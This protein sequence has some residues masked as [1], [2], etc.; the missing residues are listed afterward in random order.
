MAILLI[1]AADLEVL[2]MITVSICEDEAYFMSELNKLMDEYCDSRKIHASIVTFSDGEK[3]LA[4]SQMSDIIL[5]DI[6]LPGNNG[7]EIV[8]HLRERGSKSLCKGC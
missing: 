2:A 8:R 3:L 6:K 7:M 4:A 5:M 1:H